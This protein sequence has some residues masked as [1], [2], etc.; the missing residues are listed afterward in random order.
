MRSQFKHY[1]IDF[2]NRMQFYFKI[3]TIKYE[4]YQTHQQQII[5]SCTLLS[6]I[7]LQDKHDS[8]ITA[9]LRIIVIFT[10]DMH[11]SMM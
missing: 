4:T 9:R 6:L 8:L 2:P 1:I 5:S 7:F 11:G 3:S 10:V